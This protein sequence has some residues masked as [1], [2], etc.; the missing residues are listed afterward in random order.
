MKTADFLYVSKQLAIAKC[1][2]KE[3]DTFMEA[4]AIHV[5]ELQDFHLN[6]LHKEWPIIYDIAGAVI[7]SVKK[8]T[9]FMIFVLLLYWQG[10]NNHPYEFVIDLDNYKDNNLYKVSDNCFKAIMKSEITFRA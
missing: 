10:P 2:E 4:S 3:I 1:K 6:L 7:C 9:I 8:I 5:S